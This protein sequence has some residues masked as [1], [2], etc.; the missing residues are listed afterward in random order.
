M[1]ETSKEERLEA[2]LDLMEKD[3]ESPIPAKT[4]SSIWSLLGVSFSLIAIGLASYAAFIAF[5]LKQ[6]ASLSSPQHPETIENLLSLGSAIKSIEAQSKSMLTQEK[7]DL[8]I[9]QQ[10][11]SLSLAKKEIETMVVGLKQS[12]GTTSEDWL[13][14]EAEYLIRLANQHV[15]MEQ[16]AAGALTL[17]IAADEI[18][19]DAQGIVAYDLRKSLAEDMAALKSVGQLDTDGVFVQLGALVNQV[20]KL[21]QKKL[22]FENLTPDMHEAEGETLA[23]F[24][25]IGT[26]LASLVDY[27]RDGELVTPILPPQEDYYLR[28]NLVMKLQH[29]QLALLRQNQQIFD[30]SLSDSIVWVNQYFDLQHNVSIAMLTTLNSLQDVQVEVPMPEISGSLKEMRKLMAGF[31]AEVVSSEK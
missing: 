23:F 19:Q 7:L 24:R 30:S 22:K 27:R 25:A 29:A 28:Q 18:I 14:A 16:D 11:A 26:K 9:T 10:E 4:S 31:S 5:E 3:Q 1:S 17:L 20:S 8:S 15:K 12:I 21:E 2:A 6:S 13:L